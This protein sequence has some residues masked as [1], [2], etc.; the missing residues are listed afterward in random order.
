MYTKE[1][2]IGGLVFLESIALIVGIDGTLFTMVIATI[3]GI[4]GYEVKRIKE[5]K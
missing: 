1:M 5:K 3:A 2:A 4:A